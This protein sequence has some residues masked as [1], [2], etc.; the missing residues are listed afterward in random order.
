MIV[1]LF[2]ISTSADLID[3]YAG[4]VPERIERGSEV[5]FSGTIHN[6]GNYEVFVQ[7]FNVSFVERLGSEAN[8]APENYSYS[9][10]YAD[11]PYQ[12]PSNSTFTSL[13][14]TIIDIEPMAYNVSIFFLY[15]NTSAS[16]ISTWESAYTLANQSVL[17]IGVSDPQKIFYGF[18]IT[19]SFLAS[20]FIILVVRAKYFKN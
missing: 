8:S 16:V 7:Q 10:S 4:M 1:L 5:S 2:S 9:E 14:K 19:I 13:F 6:L 17:I 20:A 12:L 18:L 11:E 3:G 15:S